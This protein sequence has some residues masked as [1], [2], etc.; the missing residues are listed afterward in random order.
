[1]RAP[2]EVAEQIMNASPEEYRPPFISFI[3]TFYHM[4][5]EMLGEAFELLWGAVAGMLKKDHGSDEPKKD[6]HFEVCS[7]L[8]T[9]SVEQ[10]REEYS[11]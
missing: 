3:D 1:M 5:P 9:K 7:I 4:P 6:W 8:S 11:D 10:L 2:S